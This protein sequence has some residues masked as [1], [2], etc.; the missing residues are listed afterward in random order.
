MSPPAVPARV[1]HDGAKGFGE[2]STGNVEFSPV[3]D[4]KPIQLG[5]AVRREFHEHFAMVLIRV[6][7]T[8]G[9]PSS[10]TSS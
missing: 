1:I 6:S 4:R 5:L 9:Y 7:V 10:K 8:D 2:S 3:Q